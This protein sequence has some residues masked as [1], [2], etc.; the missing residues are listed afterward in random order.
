[1]TT[2][3]VVEVVEGLPSKCE[4]LSSNLVLEKEERKEGRK[5]RHRKRN[6]EKRK[7]KQKRKKEEESLEIS[8]EGCLLHFLLFC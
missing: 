6:K 2:G 8:G 7:G 1:L 4:A 3:G 5:E